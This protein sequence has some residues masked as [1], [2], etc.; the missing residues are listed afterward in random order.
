MSL[1]VR[2]LPEAREEFDR[3]IDWYS[4]R[5]KSLAQDFVARIR[6]IVKRVASNPRIHQLAYSDVRKAVVTRFPYVV[7]YRESGGELIVIGVF[8]SSRDPEEW[9]S[10]V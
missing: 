10:R 2:F 3:A 7:L 4:H 8:H 9:K 1:Q 6:D 5:G